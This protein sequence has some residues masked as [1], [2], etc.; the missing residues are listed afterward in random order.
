MSTSKRKSIRTGIAWSDVDRI[1][2]KGHD[3]RRDI[4]GKMSLGDMAFLK[5]TDR[6]PT[7]RESVCRGKSCAA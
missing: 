2:V 3:L 4:L 6:L 7:P 1:V 5:F